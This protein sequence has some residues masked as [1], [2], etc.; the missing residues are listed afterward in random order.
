M[1]IRPKTSYHPYL[2]VAFYLNCLPAD[3]VQRIPRSTR[4]E[5]SHKDQVA[6]YGH[7]WY[8]ENKQ[9]FGTLQ[10]VAASKQLLRVNRALLRVIALKRFM[11]LYQERIKGNIFQIREVVLN[12]I[13]KISEVIRCKATLKYLD[14]SYSWYLQ[15]RRKQR[16]SSSLFSL[17]R[18]QYPGQ[19]LL[20]EINVIKAY[21]TDV[22]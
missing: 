22:R 9:L 19:L 16:C 14:R 5:W 8:L 3:L 7:E 17:C 6:L 18:I 12:T 4:H 21:C 10:E 13:H 20:K 2:M 1:L 15:L 11:E